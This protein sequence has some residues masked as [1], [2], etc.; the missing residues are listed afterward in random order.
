MLIACLKFTALLAKQF[1]LSATIPKL[2]PD[3]SWHDGGWS[4]IGYECFYEKVVKVKADVAA[5]G[6]FF[7]SSPDFQATNEAKPS[8]LSFLA[9]WMALVSTL[10]FSIPPPF[11]SPLTKFPRR[12]RINE[13]VVLQVFSEVLPDATA[14]PCFYPHS[15]WAACEPGAC[16]GP[17]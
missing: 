17:I 12:Q 6:I 7:R 11:R 16:W 9:S 1:T 4:H 2:P 8:L 5:L 10:V 3:D 15:E 13:L 14:L